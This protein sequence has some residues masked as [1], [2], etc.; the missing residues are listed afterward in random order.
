MILLVKGA[1]I[2]L[3]NKCPRLEVLGKPMLT[4]PR[5]IRTVQN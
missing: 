4:R 5:N 2:A 3:A 1:S